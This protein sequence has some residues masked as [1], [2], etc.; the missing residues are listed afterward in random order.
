MAWSGDMPSATN[1]NPSLRY[2]LATEGGM[3]WTDNLMIP[4][5]AAHKGTAELLVNYYYD[6][7]VNAVLTA[8]VDYISPVKGTDEL[9]IAAN[10]DAAKNQFVIPPPDWVA[11]LHIFGPLSEADDIYFNAQFAKVIGV[12]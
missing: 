1:D 12:G 7:A 4:L 11:R 5:G 6:P 8:G 3:L 9:M 10:P 2:N